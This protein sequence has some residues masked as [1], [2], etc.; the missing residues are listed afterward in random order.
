[1]NPGVQHRR[2]LA[3]LSARILGATDEEMALDLGIP[4][5]TLRPRRMELVRMGKVEASDHQ[6]LSFAGHPAT[7]WVSCDHAPGEP[8]PRSKAKAIA[9]AAAPFIAKAEEISG[10]YPMTRDGAPVTVVVTL[11]ALRALAQAAGGVDA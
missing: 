6:R 4:A 11:G 10:K 1:M 5:N 8:P 2:I 9:E 3:Y 7:V